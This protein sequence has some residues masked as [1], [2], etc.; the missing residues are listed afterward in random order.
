MMPRWGVGAIAL[1]VIVADRVSK[2]AVAHAMGVGQ[3]VTVIPGVLWLTYILNSGAAFGLFQHGT[4][5]FIGVGLGLLAMVA[6]YLWR[7][8]VLKRATGTGLGLLAGGTVGN[9][10]DRI[11]SGRV[12]DFIHFRFFPFF[13]NLADSAIVVG[14]GL[15][16]IAQWCQDRKE[17][18]RAR[19]GK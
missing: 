8:P 1:A 10:W 4:P 9:L 5:V 17:G 11:L 3:S 16:L 12:I 2:L 15:W 7:H 6:V 18:S 19:D 14:I 13:F